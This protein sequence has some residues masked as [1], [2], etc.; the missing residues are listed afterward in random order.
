MS[1]MIPKR[2]SD[3]LGVGRDLL[4]QLN[5]R[6]AIYARICPECGDY[7]TT[8]VAEICYCSDDCRSGEYQ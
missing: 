6:A 2:L 3:E 4:R 1:Y 7:F 5:E 8:S